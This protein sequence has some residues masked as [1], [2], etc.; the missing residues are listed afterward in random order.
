MNFQNPLKPDAR[1]RAESLSVFMLYPQ[2]DAVKCVIF[3]NATRQAETKL[4]L[5]G[6]IA[7]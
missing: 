1:I 5:D 6:N 3:C 4:I 2:D 7:P